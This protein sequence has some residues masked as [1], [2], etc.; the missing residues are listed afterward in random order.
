M[1]ENFQMAAQFHGDEEKLLQ[2]IECPHYMVNIEH[3]RKVNEICAE[4]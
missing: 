1:E 4:K 3:K 2:D